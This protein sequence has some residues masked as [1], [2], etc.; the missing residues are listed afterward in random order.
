LGPVWQL[1][2]RL[3]EFGRSQPVHG[4]V[5]LQTAAAIAGLAII[6]ET[7]STIVLYPDEATRVDEYLNVEV[8]FRG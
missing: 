5:F 1:I 4:P 2:T 6:G 8:T 7:T 3:A